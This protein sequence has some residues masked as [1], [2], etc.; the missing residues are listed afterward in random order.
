M[1]VFLFIAFILIFF[2]F[3]D[4]DLFFFSHSSFVSFSFSLLF[5]FYPPQGHL[6]VARALVEQRAPLDTPV[7]SPPLWE[8]IA[9]KR[10][11][12]AKLLIQ[13]GCSVHAP[14]EAPNPSFLCAAAERG[15][16]KFVA[17]TCFFISLFYGYCIPNKFFFFFTKHR[18][19]HMLLDFGAHMEEMDDRSLTPLLC[20]AKA[21]KSETTLLLC[22]RG[23]DF[24]AVDE[25]GDTVRVVVCCCLLLF[26][27]VCCCLLLLFVV[28]VCC[29]C[30]LLFVCS[31][32]ESIGFP[33]M[34]FRLSSS[35]FLLLHPPTGTGYAC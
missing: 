16:T 26:V 21:G 13:N 12:C 35:F 22:Q 6:E 17:H 3:L 32:P 1:F 25:K 14:T 7:T 31:F 24:N 15:Q 5:T 8:A 19:V 11:D 18:L 10:W 34:F 27:V 29:C 2:L 28:V 30:L 33:D 9:N 4:P 20:A 23:A